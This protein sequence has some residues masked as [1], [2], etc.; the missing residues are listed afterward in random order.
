[1]GAA[2]HTF[3]WT[4]GFCCGAADASI[5]SDW[6]TLQ[7]SMIVSFDCGKKL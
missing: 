6:I 2:G 3:L 5:N 7:R 1:M 4:T